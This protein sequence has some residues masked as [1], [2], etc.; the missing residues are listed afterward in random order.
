[1]CIRDRVYAD[2]ATGRV[3]SRPIHALFPMAVGHAYHF[4]A[5]ILWLTTGLWFYPFLSIK[6]KGWPAVYLAFGMFYLV[7]VFPVQHFLRPALFGE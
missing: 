4:F 1:M 3:T 7:A 6:G 2:F 5:G